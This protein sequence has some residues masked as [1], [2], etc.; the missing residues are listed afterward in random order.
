MNVKVDDIRL[1]FSFV[2]YNILSCVSRVL[3]DVGFNNMSIERPV[4]Q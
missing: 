2:I 4:Y 1:T 3:P